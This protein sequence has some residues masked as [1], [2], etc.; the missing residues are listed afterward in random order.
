MFYEDLS[1]E[2]STHHMSEL[3]IGIDMLEETLMD[4]MGFT[5]YLALAKEIKR[6]GCC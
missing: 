1:R 6:E 2:W 5:E 4:S 3:I